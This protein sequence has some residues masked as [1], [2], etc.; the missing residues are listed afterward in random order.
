MCCIH[1]SDSGPLNWLSP[2]G[3][4]MQ[5]R[6]T[7]QNSTSRMSHF[8]PCA[9]AALLGNPLLSLLTRNSISQEEATWTLVMDAS[10]RLDVSHV[11]IPDRNNSWAPERLALRRI[12]RCLLGEDAPN[13]IVV[14][15]LKCLS[16][17]ARMSARGSCIS[18]LLPAPRGGSIP[19][20]EV[21]LHKIPLNKAVTCSARHSQPAGKP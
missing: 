2:C 12:Q 20:Q 7:N 6:L 19:P 21:C 10:L 5:D 9:W 18:V 4:P 13:L 3:Q 8:L 14:A 16:P 15:F 17:E 11:V 1:G